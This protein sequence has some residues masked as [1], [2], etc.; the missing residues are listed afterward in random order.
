VISNGVRRAIPILIATS[1]VAGALYL[2]LPRDEEGVAP[3]D[4]APRELRLP[5]ELA[6]LFVGAVAD[7]H[8]AQVQIEQD[9]ELAQRIFGGASIT[10]FGGGRDAPFVHEL[11]DDDSRRDVRAAL[12]E[13]FSRRSTAF[14][15]RKPRIRVDGPA[16]AEA[17]DLAFAHARGAQR[18]LPLL[19]VAG[20]GE[21]G[22]IPAEGFFTL[23]GDA[24]FTPVDLALWLD[25][26]HS[27]EPLR[28]VATT[29]FSGSFAEIVFHEADE[30]R[31]PA[32]QVH[33]GLFAATAEDEASGCDPDPDRARQEG[34]GIHFLNAM[35][36]LDRDGRP[37][38]RADV[39][40]DGRLSLL[41]AH[42]HAR[43]EGASIDV[44]TLTSERY[45]RYAVASDSAAGARGEDPIEAYVVDSLGLK[46][47]VASRVEAEE[48]LERHSRVFD[49]RTE[50]LADAAAR[51]DDAFS[52][53]RIALL[54]VVP[55]AD[56]PWNPRWDAEVRAHAGE[57]MAI[58]EDSDEAEALRI[59]VAEEESLETALAKSQAAMARLRRLVRAHENLE[60]LGALTARGGEELERYRAIRACERFTPR[61][62]TP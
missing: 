48:K 10:L 47:G 61:L 24:R 60:L 20:H 19:Y 38:A 62:N 15:Y 16:T 35:R 2:A 22:E 17:L 25:D 43:V 58:L 27:S 3:E 45:L 29:C 9:L 11:A 8:A 46:L 26:T 51:S 7:P 31:G 30:A 28:I 40:G 18:P 42:A 57:L 49:E 54:E 50:A 53:L 13:L 59:A 1:V 37:L 32:S 55:F 36:G 12:A 23:W 33:C 5:E 52:R 6:V 41:D 56:D 21:R 44:P 34:F 39:D 14:A 4:R